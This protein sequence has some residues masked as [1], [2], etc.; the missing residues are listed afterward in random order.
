MREG[1]YLEEHLFAIQAK[2]SHQCGTC[3]K[4]LQKVKKDEA[5]INGLYD[6]AETT[7]DVYILGDVSKVKSE[8]LNK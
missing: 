6:T 3:C 2:V 4:V 8:A 5:S 7:G 1:S